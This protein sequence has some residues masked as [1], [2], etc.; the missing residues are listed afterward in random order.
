VQIFY[1]P[2]YGTPATDGHW[3]HWQQ[4]GAVPPTRAAS[5]FMPVLGLYS[6]MD[7]AVVDQHMAW[8]AGAGIGVVIASWW[9]RGSREDQA[10]P[11]LLASA[12]AH[13]LRVAFHI[14]PYAGRTASSVKMDIQYIYNQYG[15][16]A[17]FLRVDAT[18]NVTTTGRGVFYVYDSLLTSALDWR[19]MLDNIRGTP[20]DAVVLSETSDMSHIDIAHF[21]GLYTYDALVD[22]SIFGPLEAN[23]ARRGALFAPSVSPGYD[24]THAVSGITHVR[25]RDNGATYDEMWDDALASGAP[26]ITITSFNEWH[27]GTQIEPALAASTSWS[28][29]YLN[30]YGERGAAAQLA[31]LQR[32]RTMVDRLLLLASYSTSPN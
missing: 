12:Q 3:L 31:Y 24:D 26:W 1:Y 14:E 28:Q 10:I 22:G 8:I 32:T 17:G 2:W 27:E 5:S 30:A 16:S 9:G 18:G 19:R 4:N 7:K 13:G 21:D 20:T 29:S 23:L 15:S 6:S 25:P 11:E